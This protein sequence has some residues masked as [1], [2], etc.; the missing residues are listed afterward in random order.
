[1]KASVFVIIISRNPFY[2]KRPAAMTFGTELRFLRQYIS[3]SP[4]EDFYGFGSPDS[5]IGKDAYNPQP[6]KKNI[7][8]T[9]VSIVAMC[10]VIVF[11]S[12]S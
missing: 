5:R 6:A 12:I 3:G 7:A 11:A 9:I 10:F 8:Q 2:A 4:A 1:M